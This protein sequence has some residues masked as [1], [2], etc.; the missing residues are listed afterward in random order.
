MKANLKH[1]LVSLATVVA[2]V[3]F[4]GCPEDNPVTPPDEFDE[5]I[6]EE[7]TAIIGSGGGSLTLQDGASIRIP[8]GAVSGE[9][10]VTLRKIGNER[11]FDAPNRSAYDLTATVD[12]TQLTFTLPGKAGLNQ[13]DFGILNYDPE[14]MEGEEIPFTYNPTTGTLTA[15]IT[16][17]RTVSGAGSASKI[18]GG[19][20]DRTRWV[21]E[22]DP[23]VEPDRTQQVIEMPF[24]QQDELTCWASSI[25]MMTR[26]YKSGATTQVHDYLKYA[27]YPPTTGPNAYM[28]RLKVPS[29]LRA[30]ADGSA[31]GTMYWRETSAFNNLVEQLDSGR[32]VVMG[33]KNHSFVVIGYEKASGTHGPSS[34]RFLVHDPGDGN[35]GNAWKEWSWL[36][37]RTYADLT[38]TE[39]WIPKPPNADRPLQTVGLPMSGATGWIRF[40]KLNDQGGPDILGVL[41]FNT[42]SSAGYGWKHRSTWASSI[43]ADVKTLELNLPLW[44][45]DRTNSASISVM[46]SI[47]QRGGGRKYESREF[48]TLPV[49]VEPQEFQLQ[50][51]VAEFRQKTGDTV[52]TLKVE[53]MNSASSVIDQFS[54][55]FAISPGGPEI[56]AIS[57]DHAKTGEEVTIDGKN[58]G[59]DRSNGSVTFGGVEATSIGSW[60]DT[61]IEVTVPD[62]ANSGDVIVTV[63]EIESNPHPFTVDDDIDIVG[64]LQTSIVGS[65]KFFGYHFLT[66]GTPL[67]DITISSAET[68]LPLEW[69][70][71]GFSV[72][73]TWREYDG[74]GGYRDYHASFSGNV[75][76]DG[77]KLERVEAVY[78]ETW[79]A[80]DNA[81][82]Q[83]TVKEMTFYNLRFLSVTPSSD[84]K[85]EL[86]QYFEYGQALRASS[87][88]VVFKIT[89]D[90][91]V[92]LEYDHSD[93]EN[94]FYPPEADVV[95]AR[96]KD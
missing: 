24:Y 73:R 22:V 11:Y 20:K 7:K 66:D 50:I 17:G 94:D 46:T 40:F 47:T 61:R 1:I 53:L 33:R 6:L 86:I 35:T 48:K 3:A 2:G 88:K 15:T 64:K 67:S 16:P 95:F 74:A 82:T 75:S 96:L 23:L 78:N 69:S 51:P 55:D 62:G 93:W 29:A 54:V 4:A 37:D 90:D 81:W 14:T 41:T 76:A 60:S 34:Y 70:G 21:T 44:N 87:M 36:A 19:L 71:T 91:V 38:M 12:P 49:S 27:G 39:I 28:Y 45:A 18:A 83:V 92:V 5:K 68:D 10:K 13:E 65:L 56:T 32:A 80:P 85:Y 58:F 8:S 57:P 43:A 25:K 84:N 59:T 52:Y 63:E 89:E 72:S 42:E 9:T 31:T 77:K 26:A 30:Y 79:V